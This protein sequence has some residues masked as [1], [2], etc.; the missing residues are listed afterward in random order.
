CV[1]P[2]LTEGYSKAWLDA[3][4]HGLPVLASEVGAARGVIGADGER[5]WLTPP[6]LSS[7]LAETI[8]CVIQQKRD[9]PALRHRCRS[10]VEARTLE[11]WG[12]TIGTICAHQWNLR[13]TEGRLR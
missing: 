12:Q 2:S 6:G 4:A 10:F 8:Q 11:A 1:Q 9:W 5:G 7:A 3:M 13:L